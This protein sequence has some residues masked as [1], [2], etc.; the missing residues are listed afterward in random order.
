[1]GG[2][3]VDMRRKSNKKY[4]RIKFRG[5]SIPSVIPTTAVAFST[6][7]P[8]LSLTDSAVCVYGPPSAFW[9]RRL[10]SLR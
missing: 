8:I 10:T 5:R 1:M 2:L 9:M 7:F 4:E 6:A 3:K